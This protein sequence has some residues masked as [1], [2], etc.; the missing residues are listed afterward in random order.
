MRL[1]MSGILPGS[2]EVCLAQILV[3]GITLGARIQTGSLL[4]EA[5]LSC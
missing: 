1:S 5:K 3:F 2:A 4:R